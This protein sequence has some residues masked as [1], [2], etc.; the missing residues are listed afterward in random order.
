MKTNFISSDLR[1]SF[2]SI[3][4][5]FCLGGISFG[6]PNYPQWWIDRG[7]VDANA[8]KNDYAMVNQGQLKNI[9]VQAVAEMDAKLTGGAGTVLHTLI[10]GWS[11][12]TGSTADYAAA[13]LGQVKNLAKPF[14]DRLIAAGYATGYPW[15]GNGNAKD[16][17][18]ANIGQ[19]KLLF[20]FDLN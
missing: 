3:A 1:L 4:A 10:A 19:V 14:Y 11:T 8:P 5:F 18:C 6:Y 12:P 7:V 20:D 2:L 9:A 17:A 13:T 16:Y 15:T